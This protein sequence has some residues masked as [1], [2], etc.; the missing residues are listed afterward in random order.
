MNRDLKLIFCKEFNCYLSPSQLTKVSTLCCRKVNR[1]MKFDC[2]KSSLAFLIRL[3]KV[4]DQR[5]S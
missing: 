1:N 4:G 5:S 2:E 3:G